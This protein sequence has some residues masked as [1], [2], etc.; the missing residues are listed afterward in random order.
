MSETVLPITLMSQERSLWCWAAVASGVSFSGIP[1][2][3][4]RVQCDIV[5]A[6]GNAIGTPGSACADPDGHNHLGELV[7]ALDAVGLAAREVDVT[8]SPPVLSQVA[9]DI[10]QGR[11]PVGVRLLN[12]FTL[13]GHFVL[14]VGCDPDTGTV[15]VADPNG[16]FGQPAPRYRMPFDDMARR[17]GAGA[18]G[19]CTHLFH[20]A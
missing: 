15:V 20:L 1:G 4:P 6:V 14:I 3:L 12:R 13:A 10:I 5:T 2:A 16:N 17:Y 8:M 9:D 11:R 7:N 18:W 19:A